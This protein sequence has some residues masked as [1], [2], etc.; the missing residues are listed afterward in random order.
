MRTSDKRTLKYFA[1]KQAPVHIKKDIYQQDT[2]RYLDTEDS[3]STKKPLV[4]FVHG[5]LSSSNHYYE[6]LVDSTLRSR[7]RM[8]A[9]DRL[10]YGYS[11]YGIPQTSISKQ[12]AFIDYVI[13][14]SKAT[15]VIVLG[16]SY[17]GP[18]AA[19]CAATNP[20]VKALIMLAPANDPEKE[21]IFWFSYFAKWKFTRLFLPHTL[22][23]SGEEKFSRA[24]ALRDILDSWQNI[25]VPTVHIHG[26][27]DYLVPYAN[28]DFSK[29]RIEKRFL[30]IISLQRV[31]HFIPWSH[32][33]LV[34]DE[35]N[36]LI[37]QLSE[38][39]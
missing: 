6:Y 26:T 31:N 9:V 24:D 18:I 11:H 39:P 14:Q 33:E 28:V 15:R 37:A 25:Q 16:H 38:Q 7:A 22:R 30:K 1:R 34:Q 12:A 36:K 21:K 5:A 35:L 23:V 2:I 29:K 4:V 32:E 10:G 17:G 8:I 19:Y 27:S 3:S 13:E 20:K